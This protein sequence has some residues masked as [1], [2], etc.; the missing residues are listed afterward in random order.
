MPES[1]SDIGRVVAELRGTRSQHS[2]AEAMRELGWPWSQATVW[3]VEKGERPLKL[4]E[5]VVLASILGTTVETLV[6]ADPDL[7]L[8]S[9]KLTQ[10]HQRITAY[11]KQI[12][13]LIQQLAETEGQLERAQQERMALEEAF[14][15]TAGP[16]PNRTQL[17]LLAHLP[18]RDE[19]LEKPRNDHF[20][21]H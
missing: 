4:R 5:A 7:V 2:L 13:A 6:G 14:L 10:V 16:N 20:G 3:S 1:D 19:S 9:N 21:E 8:I 18:L 15:A 11:E 12:A 17:G